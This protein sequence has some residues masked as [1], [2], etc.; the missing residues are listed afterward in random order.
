[1]KGRYGDTGE[2]C[3]VGK[4]CAVEQS[5]RQTL[6]GRG[7]AACRRA[8]PCG[9]VARAQKRS[10]LDDANWVWGFLESAAAASN[11]PPYHLPVRERRKLAEGITRLAS[12]LA[13]TLEENGLDAHLVHLDW[14]WFNGLQVDEDLRD[15]IQAS[16]DAE[17]REKIKLS[18]LIEG[19]AERANEKIME[20]RSVERR[21]E[22]PRH[23]LQTVDRKAQSAL[24]QEAPKRRRGGEPRTRY[25][26]RLTC[27]SDRSKAALALALGNWLEGAI[28]S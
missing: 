10:I 18:I 15:S 4:A 3:G 17:G 27:E 20:E 21:S 26:E 5:I 22:R 11:L 12:S 7:K 14:K 2:A 1:M 9:D 16:I 23:P 6:L 13:K 28:P 19:M 24:V 8:T 25:S